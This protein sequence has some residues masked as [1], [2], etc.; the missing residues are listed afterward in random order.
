MLAAAK[1]LFHHRL[2]LSRDQ[3]VGAHPGSLF[4]HLLARNVQRHVSCLV[5][6][7]IKPVDYVENLFQVQSNHLLL[8]EFQVCHFF[9]F[10]IEMH[11]RKMLAKNFIFFVV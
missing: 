2:P 3:R 11:R 7:Q 9:P 4:G 10:K 6:I 1:Y 5:L 8:D